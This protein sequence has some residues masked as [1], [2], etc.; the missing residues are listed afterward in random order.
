MQEENPT[1]LLREIR[2]LLE[3]IAAHYRP[4]FEERVRMEHAEKSRLLAQIVRGDQSRRACLM[5]DGNNEQATIRAAVGIGSGNLSNLIS[6][7]DDAGM[8]A[9]DSDRRNPQLIFQQ[10]EL[11]EIFGGME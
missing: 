10:W 11:R 7:L 4:E 9:G 5:M 8:L 2:D 3:P 1:E 6:R